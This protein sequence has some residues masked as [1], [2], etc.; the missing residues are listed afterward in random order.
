MEI[1]KSIFEVKPGDF[2]LRVGKHEVNARFTE[3]APCQIEQ[4]VRGP[5]GGHYRLT[6]VGASQYRVFVC[7]TKRPLVKASDPVIILGL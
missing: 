6:A 5:R 2:V 7:G 1:R 4:K 3:I